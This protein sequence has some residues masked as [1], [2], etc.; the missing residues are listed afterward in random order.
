MKGVTLNDNEGI[1]V[2]EPVRV[3]VADDDEYLRKM[4]SRTLRD[5]GLACVTMNDGAAAL[6]ALEKKH[7]DVALVDLEMPKVDGFQMLAAMQ[8]DHP[9]TIAIV[10]TGTG[11][12]PRAVKAM[13]LGAFDFLEKP[14]NPDLLLSAIR[15]ATEYCRAQRRAEEKE[16]EADTY[17]SA[18]QQEQAS[19]QARKLQSIGRLASGIAHEINTPTQY[20]GD[21]IEF[22]QSAYQSFVSLTG[23]LGQIV[24]AAATGAV[25]PQLLAEAKGLIEQTNLDYLRV[26]VPRAIDQSLEGVERISSIV[27]AMKEFSH[28][29]SSEKSPVDLNQCI[30]STVMV[31]RN[32]WKYSAELELDLEGALPP[33]RCLA[34]ELNQVFLNLIVNAAHAIGD[35]LGENAVKKGTI[36]ITTRQDGD[37]VEIRI[38]DTGSGIPESVREHIFDP[39]FTTKGVGRGTGQGLAIA[40]SVVVDKHGGELTFETETGAGTTFI[41]RLPILAQG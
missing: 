41:I 32:E 39:F 22:L 27:L 4:V 8:R 20:V 34:G 9:N 10:L 7:F 13:K 3:L 30:R 23:M 35:A 26:Q 16:A 29:G 36:T 15:R 31:S 14:C 33:V 17:R 12:I 6:E 1:D 19:N 38:A 5:H 11:D 18:L 24:D 21:N 28:P 25:A 37:W 2:A 40:R